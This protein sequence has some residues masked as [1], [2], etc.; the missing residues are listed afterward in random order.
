VQELVGDEVELVPFPYCASDGPF[1][2]HL[3]QHPSAGFLLPNDAFYE[4]VP[5]EE[6]VKEDSETLRGHELEIGHEYH[7]V[8]TTWNGLYRYLIGDVVLV[9]GK[10]DSGVPQLEYVGRRQAFSSFTGEKLTDRHVVAAAKEAF[11]RQNV[12]VTNYTCCPCWGEPPQYVFVVEPASPEQ[13]GDFDALAG[14][15]DRRLK[16]CN[17]EYPSKRKSGRLGPVVVHVVGSGTFSRYRQKL[18]DQGA[19]AGQLKDKPL[20]KDGTVLDDILVAGSRV[21]R[22]ESDAT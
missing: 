5:A 7:L 21:G 19:P 18:I 8:H 2:V 14:E 1:A 20:Q 6:Q 17:D 16:N 22:G 12:T 4:F 9:R 13:V 3:D 10:L 11:E 15:L